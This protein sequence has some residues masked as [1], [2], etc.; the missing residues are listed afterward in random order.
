MIFFLVIF[1]FT[2]LI[3]ATRKAAAYCC[4][5]DNFVFNTLSNSNSVIVV[6]NAS[7]RNYITTSITHIYSFSSPIKKTLHYTIDITSTEAELFAIRCRINQAVQIDDSSCIIVITGVLH[8]VQKI[9][10]S[11]IHPYHL[12]SIAI[13]KDLRSFFNKHPSNFIEFWDCL[14]N[15]EW[16]LHALV[17][18]D[19]KKF[20][21]TPLFP[22]KTS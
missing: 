4:K 5:L 15:E 11:S 21:L 6:S 10:D 7:I 17:D 8:V 2:K 19:M 22:C 1:H 9:F 18:K 3:A 12:Q 16:P 13:S 14:S 20:N